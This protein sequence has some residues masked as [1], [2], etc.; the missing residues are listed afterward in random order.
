M[1]DAL[2]IMRTVRLAADLHDIKDTGATSPILLT[3]K[4]LDVAMAAANT[5]LSA[6]SPAFGLTSLAG[7][8]LAGL[9]L[10][11]STRITTAQVPWL[12][13]WSPIDGRTPTAV[14][15]QVTN[16]FCQ[17]L[18]AS[19]GRRSPDD[20]VTYL[21]LPDPN[22]SHGDS[23]HASI[24]VTEPS[25]DHGSISLWSPIEGVTPD[26][27]PQLP[28]RLVGFTGK[29]AALV[30]KMLVYNAKM[31]DFT[32]ER[33]IHWPTLQSFVDASLE[34]PDYAWLYVPPNLVPV[35]VSGSWIYVKQPL[36][37]HK[38]SILRFVSPNAVASTAS[39]TVTP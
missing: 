34:L 19:L 27:S 36:L 15:E 29:Q 24:R 8:A 17:G 12:L 7:G 13:V 18:I 23:I 14:G 20:K 3:G 32:M 5:G 39:G 10:L 28:T 1:S 11:T 25:G 21:P 38:G 6:A 37:I 16:R 26:N 9:N 35:E 30:V 22:T 33:T 2:L 31:N 4:D